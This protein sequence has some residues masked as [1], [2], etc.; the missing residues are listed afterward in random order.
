M[1]TPLVYG[2]YLY[3]CQ[4]NGVLSCYRAKSGERLYRKRLGGGRMGFSASPV[5][6]DGK[7]Y[8]TSEVGDVFRRS[9]R[10]GVRAPGH[11]FTGRGRDGNASY[12]R[13]RAVLPDEEPYRCGVP[14]INAFQLRFGSKARGPRDLAGGPWLVRGPGQ[15]VRGSSAAEKG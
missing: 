13:G 1:Q 2:E 3:N 7:I 8:F 11:E 10:T 15:R 12:L 9:G 4:E 14:E 6:A 5:A